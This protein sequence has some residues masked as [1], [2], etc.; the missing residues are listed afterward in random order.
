MIPH[1]AGSR[2]QPVIELATGQIRNWPEG[3]TADVF[4]KVC[5]DGEYWLADQAGKRLWKWNGHYVPDD[6]LCIGEQGFGDY[7][8][9]R[10]AAN[11]LIEGWRAPALDAGEWSP[12]DPLNAS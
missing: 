5:D 12:V 7:I 2:W 1:R 4:F 9:F 8:V 11:G 10:V 6:L 3:T